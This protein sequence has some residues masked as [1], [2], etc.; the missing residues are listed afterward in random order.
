M[1]PFSQTQ[2]LDL[3]DPILELAVAFR[4]D[5]R[6]QKVDLAIGTYRNEQ[7]R[8]WV[9]P[10]IA[11]AEAILESKHL[12]KDY[13]PIDGDAEFLNAA[14][15]SLLGKQLSDK[16]SRIV[17]VQTVGGTSALR[18][19]A[20]YLRL[21]EER[22][23]YISDPTWPNH[24]SLCQQA[25]LQ[26]QRYPYYNPATK[27]I[28][29]DGI[30]KALKSS[31]KG[32][33]WLLQTCCH[34]PTGLD[35][36]HAE[37]Q[38]LIKALGEQ[39]LFPFFDV[40][41]QGF[42]EG[43]E[44]DAYPIRY[45]VEQGLECFI[46]NSFSKNFGVYGERVGTLTAVCASA[47]A[48]SHVRKQLKTLIRRMYSNPPLHGARLVKTLLTTPLL[49]KQWQDELEQMRLHIASMR[50]L[51]LKTLQG[52]ME[53]AKGE[54]LSFLSNQRGLFSYGYLT[55]PQVARLKEDFAIYLPDNGRIAITG[56][57]HQNLEYV[58]NSMLSVQT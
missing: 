12:D 17:T 36:S 53:Q 56:L 26:V 1:S 4:K 44:Q 43:F 57:T 23:V 15:E 37:W 18:L 45:C 55:T 24:P 27:Q 58:V 22:S 50:T 11:Q 20:D 47:E 39:A 46:A 51:F 49:R 34:N 9:L 5:P 31:Q 7:G 14:T 3:D 40:A 32:S 42:A 16:A 8:S 6:P 30:L 13:L 54:E 35:F 29:F 48:A 2:G 28:D 10:S 25:R 41:Y 19:A 52:K 21:A 38:Q 33:A